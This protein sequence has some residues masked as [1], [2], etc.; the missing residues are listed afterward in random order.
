MFLTVV[1]IILKLWLV[2]PVRPTTT[3]L[4]RANVA[5]MLSF[6]GINQSINQSLKE[7]EGN[8]ITVWLRY[9]SVK[10]CGPLGRGEGV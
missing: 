3:A 1:N 6:L 5:P 9:D 4:I 7:Y 8:F 10:V 2:A